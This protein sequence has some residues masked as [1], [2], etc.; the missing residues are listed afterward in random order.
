[1]EE[2]LHDGKGLKQPICHFL[3]GE[4]NIAF[5]ALLWPL[6]LETKVTLRVVTSFTLGKEIHALYLLQNLQLYH[7]N[8]TVSEFTE[9]K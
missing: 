6:L 8:H 5:P 2:S 3:K 7:Y 9:Q 1:M 4:Y